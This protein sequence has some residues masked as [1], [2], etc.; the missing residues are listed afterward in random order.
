[1]TGI[2]IP[3]TATFTEIL[4]QNNDGLHIQY[5]PLFGT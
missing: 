2:N 3:I 4:I 5:N 1:M